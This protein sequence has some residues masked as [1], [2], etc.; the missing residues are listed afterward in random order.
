MFEIATIKYD[1]EFKE[2]VLTDLDLGNPSNPTDN[3]LKQA[4]CIALETPDL[5]G[6]AVER[7]ETTIRVIP[8]PTFAK[9]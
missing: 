2:Y 8:D 1:G 3:E 7:Y 9:D 4:L 5:N 6:F